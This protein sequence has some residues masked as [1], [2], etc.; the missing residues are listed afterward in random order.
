MYLWE[1]HD[2]RKR[3][4]ELKRK[5]PQAIIL[6][7]SGDDLYLTYFDSA[8]YLKPSYSKQYY[9]N[10]KG[11]AGFCIQRDWLAGRVVKLDAYAWEFKE[12]IHVSVKT[13]PAEP[14]SKKFSPHL[15]RPVEQKTE[16][17]CDNCML[18][19]SGEC[20]QLRNELCNSYRAIPYV[21]REEKESRPKYGDATAFRFGEK[22]N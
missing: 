5:Y 2:T 20:P 13:R 1:A 15:S 21:S 22:R 16:A 12:P 3:Y 7:E 18:R 14:A 17:S 11:E 19:K 8:E 10:S 6:L 9:S 4:K